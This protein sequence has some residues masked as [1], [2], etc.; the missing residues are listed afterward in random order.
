MANTAGGDLY[1]RPQSGDPLVIPAPV[2]RAILDTVDYVKQLR[3]RTVS[4]AK[5]KAVSDY[6]VVE[7]KNTSDAAVDRFGILGID[8]AWPDPGDNLQAFKNGPI[9]HCITPDE[10]IHVGKFVVML[11]PLPIDGIGLACV[12]GVVPV[13]IE[14][15]YE[16]RPYADILDAETG[17]LGSDW[18]GA[19]EILYCETGTGTKWALVRL[20]GWHDAHPEGVLDEDLVSASSAT[21]SVV[22]TDED[23]TVYAPWIMDS[24]Q[25]DEDARIE[26]EWSRRNS[27][28]EP[29]KRWC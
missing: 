17:K 5:R 24:G 19:A 6:G 9:L 23:L 20:G 10:D 25:L 18:R 11:E 2:W 3:N 28:W 14:V 21:L 29:Y 22:G 1:K 13:Q 4:T 27:R 8:T 7:V 15:S 26:V 16:D 12:S